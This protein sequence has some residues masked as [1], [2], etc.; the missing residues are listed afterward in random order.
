MAA[1]LNVC[2]FNPTAGGTTDW[3]YSSAV[4][5]YQSP[6]LAGVVNGTLYKYRAESADL[7]QWELGEGAYNT[8][9]GVLARTTVLYNS[10]GTGTGAGQSGAG[11]K[12]SFSAAPQV[13]VVALKEDLVPQTVGHIPGEVST[14]NAAAG[15]IG[16]LIEFTLGSTAL[17]T[18]AAAVNLANGAFSAGDWDICGFIW[19][20]AAGATTLTN[21]QFSVSSTS[22]TVDG[23]AIDR[24][25]QFRGSIADPIVSQ[26]IGPH[27]RS[28]S[29]STTLYL[30]ATASFS[31]TLNVTSKIRG[32]RV[33]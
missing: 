33:R 21:Y 16:E 1:F 6:A 24:Y 3:T 31:S 29:A 11:T 8:G 28:F 27:R 10:S 15:E 7:S 14:G 9:T 4:T 23:S 25:V 30:T 22:A 17:T 5:G 13:A 2:R 18:G 20:S 32:R 26:V 19:I 12:I